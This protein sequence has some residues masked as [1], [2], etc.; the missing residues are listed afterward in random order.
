M[1][2]RAIQIVREVSAIKMDDA[3]IV[4][5]DIMAKCVQTHVETAPTVTVRMDAKHALWEN[6]G[7]PV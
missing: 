2:C 1:D 3:T 4:N 5:L 7:T 6:G